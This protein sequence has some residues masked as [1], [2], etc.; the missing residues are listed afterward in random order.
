MSNEAPVHRHK[1]ADG[2]PPRQP[3]GWQLALAAAAAATTW[4]LTRDV[5]LSVEVAAL[6]LAA[7]PPSSA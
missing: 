3:H 4:S 5:S 1:P 2:E 7:F 6:A